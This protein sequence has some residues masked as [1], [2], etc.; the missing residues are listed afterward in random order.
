MFMGGDISINLMPP[1]TQEYGVTSVGSIS[2]N[3]TLRAVLRYMYFLS[4]LIKA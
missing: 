1:L 3:I 4:L 2:Q